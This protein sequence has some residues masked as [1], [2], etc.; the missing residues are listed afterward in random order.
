M[1]HCERLGEMFS[2]QISSYCVSSHFN[3]E[4]YSGSGTW[5]GHP[6]GNAY[7]IHI[8]WGGLKSS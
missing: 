6:C 4:L 3:I 2:T 8:R 1:D 5:S 7:Q